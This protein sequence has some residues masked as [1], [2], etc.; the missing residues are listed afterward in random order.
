[1][2][3]GRGMRRVPS[4][5][6]RALL[7]V[8][9]AVLAASCVASAATNPPSPSASPSA[10]ASRTP[11]ASP[12][13]EPT[14]S[15]AHTPTPR[16]TPVLVP[17]P[18]TGVLVTDAVAARRAIAVMVDDHADARP[19]S[20]FTDASIVW[21]APAE[22]GIPRYM[23]VFGE[24]V[25]TDIG[26]VR[27]ARDY[28]VYWAGEWNALFAHSGGSPGALRLLRNQGNGELVYNADEFRWG[29]YFRR[30]R[31]RFAPHNLYTDGE[32][33]RELAAELGATD[34]PRSPV[35]RFAN[36]APRAD[37]PTGGSVE[38]AFGANRVRFDYDRA[39]NTYLRSVSGGTRHVDAA[40]A[41]RV[42]PK[43]VVVMHVRF[44]SL[45]DGTNKGRLDADLVGSG[46][47]WVASNGTTVKG[48]WRKAS[49]T[50][51]SLFFDA[52]G[53][54]VTFARG[55]TFIQVMPVDTRVT[56]KPGA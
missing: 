46:T 35:W 5:V 20:G 21:H 13:A 54:P 2:V 50:D 51:P 14:P 45:N 25:P 19:Q 47:A 42:A 49:L 24:T 1:M 17:A 33:M 29:R 38:T 11:S 4:S 23:L 30:V 7:L 28:F 44:G 39:S 55:Q 22:G 36:D 37:R 18:L 41:E 34:E 12:S 43:N 26:P 10:D 40:S 52:K 53:R 16:P 48:T 9:V 27:S 32:Q 31:S 6:E 8:L 56:V 15:P 3:V